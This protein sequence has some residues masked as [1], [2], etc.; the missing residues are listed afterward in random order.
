[1]FLTRVN[2][3]LSGNDHTL[4]VSAEIRGS[5]RRPT[6]PGLTADSE[7]PK[8]TPEWGPTGPVGGFAG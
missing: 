4:K 8:F 3:T 6:R 2:I 1:M 7:S 5:E